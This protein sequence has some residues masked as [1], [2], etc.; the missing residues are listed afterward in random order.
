MFAPT[1]GSFDPTLTLL[2]SWIELTVLR[3]LC[4]E[5]FEIAITHWAQYPKTSFM[6]EFL[7]QSQPGP[8]QINSSMHLYVFTGIMVHSESWVCSS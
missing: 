8:L 6:C 1:D 4:M 7:T 5:W 3:N 2:M